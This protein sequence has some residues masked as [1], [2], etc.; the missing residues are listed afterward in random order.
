[1]VLTKKELN[2][3]E[4]LAN[5]EKLPYYK[6]KEVVYHYASYSKANFETDLED[7]VVLTSTKA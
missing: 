5:L 3:D 4:V 6:F 1:M 7:M 2:F